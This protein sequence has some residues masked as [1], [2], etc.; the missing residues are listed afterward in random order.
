MPETR[1]F[2]VKNGLK[3]F[4]PESVNFSELKKITKDRNSENDEGQREFPSDTGDSGL[5][6]EQMEESVDYEK[7]VLQMLCNLDLQEKLVFM[8]QLFRDS[9]YQI[10][11]G[12]F[13]RTLNV[14]RLEYMKM[15]KM[16]KIKTILMIEG[17][18]MLQSSLK[19]AQ[20]GAK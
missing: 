13:A 6:V 15:L 17:R 11:H 5:A 4:V 1:R 18:S 20:M 3:G 7:L 2:K 8:Y 9:G 14:S 12:S 10:D 16:V 19:D